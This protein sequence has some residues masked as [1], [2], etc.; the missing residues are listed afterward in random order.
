[1]VDIEVMWSFVF[2]IQIFF[3]GFLAIMVH[4]FSPLLT[5]TA[6]SFE[7]LANYN[8]FNCSQLLLI[9]FNC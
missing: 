5:L 3:I 8:C 7:H 9:T 1:M 2:K 4:N 6:Y